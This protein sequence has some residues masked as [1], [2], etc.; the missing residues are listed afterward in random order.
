MVNTLVSNRE[1]S[2]YNPEYQRLVEA[3]VRA[4]KIRDMTQDDLSR[5]TGLARQAISS[6]ENCNRRIDALELHDWLKAVKAEPDLI[7]T[8]IKSIRKL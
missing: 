7:G 3:L 4:R 5:A 2:L 1:L 8:I 6:I